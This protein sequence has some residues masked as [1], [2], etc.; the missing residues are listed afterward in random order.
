VTPLPPPFVA[1]N[2]NSNGGGGDDAFLKSVSAP[3][4]MPAVSPSRSSLAARQATLA[5][6][7]ATRSGAG[8]PTPSAAGSSAL[9]LSGSLGEE[10]DEGKTHIESA[11]AS[12]ATSTSE[13]DDESS[14][15]SKT[16]KKRF[17]DSFLTTRASREDVSHLMHVDDEADELAVAASSDA[18]DDDVFVED[19]SEWTKADC[20]APKWPDADSPPDGLALLVKTECLQMS[21]PESPD[22]VWHLEWGFADAPANPPLEI[23]NSE[24]DRKFYREFMASTS[25][26]HY[27][28]ESES[29]GPI[30]VSVGKSNKL[31]H[32]QVIVRT[33]HED[34]RF[35]I[36]TK[37]GTQLKNLLAAAPALCADDVRL[38]KLSSD[39]LTARLCQFEDDLICANYKFGVLYAQSGQSDENDMFGN[40]D[41]SSKWEKFLQFLGERVRLKGWQKFRGGLD[42]KQDSTGTHS[43]YT[44]FFTF[45]IMYHVSTLLPWNPADVQQLERKRHL[46]ND[47][48]VLVFLDNPADTFDS[49]KMA[50]HFNH[51]Y[52][53]ATENP[54]GSGGYLL[55][56]INKPGVPRYGPALPLPAVVPATPKGRQ[57]LLSKLINAERASTLHT[58]TFRVKTQ[59]TRRMLLSSI[60]ADF[61]PSAKHVQTHKSIGKT[62]NLSSSSS[63]GRLRIRPPSLAGGQALISP[64]NKSDS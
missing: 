57:F 44:Q 21:T 29:Q 14:S 39:E 5:A 31:H 24:L 8:S 1:R 27:L 28:A 9:S 30:V 6:A 56:V 46:G 32:A 54:D 7:L 41:G 23:E 64:R 15:A 18:V 62:K 17:L 61:L 20:V 25:H 49:L 37:R 51:V 43:V 16:K 2:N 38:H 47:I 63:F 53:V 19:T 3:R 48:V 45:E 22:D 36:S 12:W 52:V 42:V 40:M 34:L 59:R 11:L 4:L 60:V 13:V 35:V 10:R 33:M 26:S 55:N 58:P 50:S